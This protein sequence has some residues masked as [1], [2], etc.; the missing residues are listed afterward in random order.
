MATS[1]KSAFLIDAQQHI[2]A[3]CEFVTTMLAPLSTELLYRQPGST[4]WSVLQCFEHINLTQ[5][6]YRPKIDR[7]LAHPVAAA[8]SDDSYKPSF[9]A[10]T[11][12]HFAFNPRYSFASPA[13]TTPGT[14][15]QRDVLAAYLEN[16]G[17]L[18]HTLDDVGRIDLRRT[19]VPIEKGVAFNLGDCLRI[20]VHHD[21]LHI[22]QAQN[23]L[24][25]LRQQAA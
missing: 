18:L 8:A 23:V 3:H 24:A 11:Y 2:H 5:D 19:K 20:L 13:D 25:Q 4:E 21:E 14:P 7:A 16:Q 15:I 6:Y 12:M 9:W 17:A 22:K 1:S 10:R